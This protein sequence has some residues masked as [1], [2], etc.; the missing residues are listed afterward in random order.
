MQ[1]GNKK[2]SKGKASKIPAKSGRK[3]RRQGKKVKARK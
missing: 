3:E 1:L 2:R